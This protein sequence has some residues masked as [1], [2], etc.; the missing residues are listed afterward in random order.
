MVAIMH[1]GTTAGEDRRS[2]EQ[3]DPLDADNHPSCIGGGRAQPERRFRRLDGLL[4]GQRA[5]G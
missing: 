3:H 4:L 1:A 5:N 2:L